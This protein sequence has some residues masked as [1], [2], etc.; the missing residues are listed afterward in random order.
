MERITP[1]IAP[2]HRTQYSNLDRI[3][4]SDQLEV[5]VCCVLV[6][7]NRI[8]LL[9]SAIASIISQTIKPDFVVIVDNNSSDGTTDYM[10]RLAASRTDIV[11]IILDRNYGGAGGFYYGIKAATERDADWIWTLDDDTVA[12]STALE[13]LLDSARSQENCRS[14]NIGFL[15]SRVNWKDGS[16]HQMNVPGSLA[17]E[18]PI[19]ADCKEFKQIEYASFVSILIQRKA[20]EHV[21]LPIKEFFI[22][23]D[24]VEYTKRI[25]NAGFTAYYVEQSIVE[26]LTQKNQGLTLEEMDVR[27]DNLVKWRYAIRNLVVLDRQRRLGLVRALGRICQVL[28]TMTVNRVSFSLQVDLLSAAIQGLFFNYDHWL[29]RNRIAIRMDEGRDI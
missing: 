23:F 27:P 21:G 1:A 17:D 11:P 2:V 12:H 25:T 8:H 5:C 26:H 29:R 7:H 16:V 13:K 6:T 20:I 4:C 3:C 18:S 9:R 14:D 15:A 24:D 28:W 22:C 10:E 19:S